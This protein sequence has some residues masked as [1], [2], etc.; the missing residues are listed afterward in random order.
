M[1]REMYLVTYSLNDTSVAEKKFYVLADE[2]DISEMRSKLWDAQAA[3]LI[4][5]SRTTRMFSESEIV[6]VKAL[7][8]PLKEFR[9][10]RVT[11]LTD[12]KI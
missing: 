1:S 4:S 5:A 11:E 3:H 7:L 6:G 12:V 2:D 9:D 10:K 8:L